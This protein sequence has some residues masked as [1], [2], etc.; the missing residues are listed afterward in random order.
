MYT[1][2]VLFDFQLNY[3]HSYRIHHELFNKRIPIKVCGIDGY[4]VFPGL[5]EGPNE[6][7]KYLPEENPVGYITNSLGD[8]YLSKCLCQFT[9]KKELDKSFLADCQSHVDRLI[10][11]LEYYK[12]GHFGMTKK[13][14][15]HGGSYHIDC[16]MYQV[17]D[18]ILKIFPDPVPINIGTIVIGRQPALRRNELKI[19]FALCIKD[20][21][22]INISHELY[23]QSII[24]LRSNI[25]HT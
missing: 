25:F 15:V 11:L 18:G 20:T 13:L 14:P 2:N 17:G 12:F 4:V 8:F 7:L 21:L 19:L 3:L 6:V 24:W 10:N 23:R 9:S 1:Y 16:Y 22:K 5:K